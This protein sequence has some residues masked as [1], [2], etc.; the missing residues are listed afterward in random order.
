[1]RCHAVVNAVVI[2]LSYGC[3]GVANTVVIGCCTEFRRGNTEFHGGEIRGPDR[4][5][6]ICEDSMPPLRAFILRIL[7]TGLNLSGQRDRTRK[8]LRKFAEEAALQAQRFIGWALRGIIG[9]KTDVK[10]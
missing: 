2:Q 7:E 4:F 3:H 9:L 6:P 1:M 10:S 5:S 8:D